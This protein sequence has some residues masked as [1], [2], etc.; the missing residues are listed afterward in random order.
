MGWEYVVGYF[1]FCLSAYA[2]VFLTWRDNMHYDKQREKEFTDRKEK[3]KND[4][5]RPE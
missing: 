3:E 4:K 1:L 5:D 2:I